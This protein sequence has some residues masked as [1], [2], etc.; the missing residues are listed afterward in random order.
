MSEPQE[1]RKPSKL[2]LTYIVTAVAIS[3]LMIGASLGIIIKATTPGFPTVIEPGSMMSEY[4]YVVF[5][6]GSDTKLRDGSTGAIAYSSTSSFTAIQY[7]ISAVGNAGGG[8]IYLKLGT[9][10]IVGNLNITKSNITLS[11]DP[12]TVILSSSIPVLSIWGPEPYG[13]DFDPYHN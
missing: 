12:G 1:T 11:A 8:S 4:S 2:K 7:A 3:C 6:D 5:Q 10:T 13:S 9:Y